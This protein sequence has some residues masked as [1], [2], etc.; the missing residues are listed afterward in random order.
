[1]SVLIIRAA[2][3]PESA[4]Y[5]FESNVYDRNPRFGTRARIVGHSIGIIR[6]LKK[7]GEIILVKPMDLDKGY[8]CFVRA[9]QLIRAHWIAKV[10]PDRIQWAGRTIL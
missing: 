6:V 2:E 3:T 5:R 9:G 1:M 7:T 10:L 8:K 4:D